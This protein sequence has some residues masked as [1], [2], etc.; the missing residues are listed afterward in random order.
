MKIKGLINC[1]GEGYSDLKSGEEREVSEKVGE[2]L[3]SFGYAEMLEAGKTES[4]TLESKTYE[5]LKEIAKK[6]LIN[7]FGISKENLIE[8]IKEKMV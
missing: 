5:E 3:V 2:L 8:K 6:Y 4:E 7:T 1:T